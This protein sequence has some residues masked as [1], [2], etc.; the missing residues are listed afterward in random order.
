MSHCAVP[1]YNPN[2]EH[3]SAPCGAHRAFP[4]C[5]QGA[6]YPPSACER[7]EQAGERQNWLAGVGGVARGLKK[8]KCRFGQSKKLTFL[9]KRRNCIC[10]NERR[11]EVYI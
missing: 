10:V 8:R 1:L 9:I 2:F 7:R 4:R 3:L 5:A 6:P 11:K